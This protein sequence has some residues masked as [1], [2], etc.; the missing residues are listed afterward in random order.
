MTDE[1]GTRA[2]FEGLDVTVEG[3]EP[4]TGKTTWSVPMG[5]AETLV[6]YRA[7]RPIAGPTQIV[8]SRPTG[9]VLLDYATGSVTAPPAGATFWCMTAMRYE[10]LPAYTAWDGTRRYDRPGGDLATICDAQGRPSEELPGAAATMAAGA[11]VGGYAVIAA[12]NG[13]VGFRVP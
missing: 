8:V 1:A 3:F 10:T 2:S 4:T 6:D 12:R 11:H 9:P 5:A 13:Y 7:S